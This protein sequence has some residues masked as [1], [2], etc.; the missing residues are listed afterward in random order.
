MSKKTLLIAIG[1]FTLVVNVALAI[2]FTL[3]T[4]EPEPKRTHIVKGSYDRSVQETSRKFVTEDELDKLAEEKRLQELRE[5]K[6]LEVQ[7]GNKKESDTATSKEETTPSTDPKT[8]TDSTE[9]KPETEE[10]SP[11]TDIK[12]E[13][14]KSESV[15]DEV[16][17]E[18]ENPKELQEETLSIEEELTPVNNES[19]EKVDVA[20]SSQNE[21]IDN[22]VTE[23]VQEKAIEAPKVQEEAPVAEEPKV[24]E[25]KKEE[26]PKKEPKEEIKEEKAKEET[27][28]LPKKT[29]NEITMGYANNVLTVRVVANQPIKGRTLYVGNPERAILDLEGIWTLPN[30]PLFPKN[31]Y[32]TDIRVGLQPDKTRFVVDITTKKFT[33][34]L[35]QLND[36]TIELRINF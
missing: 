9:A 21:K 30:M 34:R 11:V 25:V 23:E 14:D 8:T 12:P 2:Y 33:R 10:I 6:L 35:V 20:E 18:K 31:P 17:T 13:V 28:K 7:A 3:P 5:Q 16:V 36:R 26:E 15:K 4:K 32:S 24:E 19:L 27:P 22:E 29:V 1:G